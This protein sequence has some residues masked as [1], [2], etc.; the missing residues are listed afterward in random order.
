MVACSLFKQM[1]ESV[2]HLYQMGIWH[3]DIK[4]DNF[5]IFDPVIEEEKEESE[6]EKKRVVSDEKKLYEEN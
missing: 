4:P 1:L 6:E 5:L 3:R 2:A